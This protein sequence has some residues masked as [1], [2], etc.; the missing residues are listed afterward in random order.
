MIYTFLLK[1]GLKLGVYLAIAGS[2]YAAGYSGYN[3]IFHKGVTDATVKYEALLLAKDQELAAKLEEILVDSM[4]LAKED[5]KRQSR[6]EHDL[7]KVL[8]NSVK[9]PVTIVKD[10]VCTPTQAF[11]DSFNSINARVNESIKESQK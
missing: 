1:Y 9:E 2:I 4:N 7:K 8:A 6:L 3:W 5:A 10:G 11:S